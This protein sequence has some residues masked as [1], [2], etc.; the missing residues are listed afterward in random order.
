MRIQVHV[1]PRAKTRS[2]QSAPDGTLLVKVT[3]P[4]E[5]GR[6]NAAVIAAVAAHFGVPKRCVTILRGI[7]SRQKQIDIIQETD[8]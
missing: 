1:T 8:P 3:E 5:E 2:V 4:A 7:T 6:A